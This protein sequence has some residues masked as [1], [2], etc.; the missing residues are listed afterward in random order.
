MNL[1]QYFLYTVY[2]KAN[3]K[4]VIAERREKILSLMVKGYSQ[5]DMC[6]ELGVTRQTISKDMK[7][8]MKALKKDYS[9]LSTMFFSCMD[10]MN[11]VQ[12]ECWKIYRNEDNNPE[13]QQWARCSP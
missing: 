13:I 9:G 11:Q 6:K 10:G 4:K 8:I 1:L 2:G 12:R 5:M 7:W 3:S